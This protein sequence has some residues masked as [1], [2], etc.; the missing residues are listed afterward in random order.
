MTITRLAH[1]QPVPDESREAFWTPFKAQ[2]ATFP[3]RDAELLHGTLAIGCIRALLQS[4]SKDH[5]DL[6]ALMVRL[7]ECVRW[8][9]IRADMLRPLVQKYFLEREPRVATER[10]QFANT[11]VVW[12]ESTSD[13]VRAQVTS[14]AWDQIY[15]GIES[16]ASATDSALK[17]LAKNNRALAT[18]SESEFSRLTE[19]SSIVTWLLAGVRSDGTP[20]MNL[21]GPQLAVEAGLD[22]ASRVSRTL[23]PPN[24]A[25]ILNKI[26]RVVE[27]EESKASHTL[28]EALDG[29]T[30]PSRA[31]P[32]DF[33]DLAPIH[34]SRSGRTLSDELAGQQWSAHE[35]S[36]LAYTEALTIGAWVNLANP[37]K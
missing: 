20:W 29:V 5:A 11:P 15:A 32:D 23:G 25:E 36:R 18:W 6:T 12:T 4:K 22:L 14:G 7:A 1:S 24:A 17:A 28:A 33:G 30:A 16:I 8:E 10:P 2:D 37:D 3:I 35:L 9:P 19:E 31:A 27:K 21:T 34:W 13:S 26:L